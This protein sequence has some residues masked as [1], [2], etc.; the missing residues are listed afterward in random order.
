MEI[1]HKIEKSLEQ[2][3]KALPSLPNDTKKGLASIWPW[4]AL[5]AGVLQ[6]LATWSL[7]TFARDVN[8]WVD[9]A[10][11]WSVAFGGGRVANSGFTVWVW[12][13]IVVLAVDAI[14]L[15]VAFP[16]LQKK[17][18]S[19]WDLLFLAA[20]INVVYGVVSLFIDGRGGAGSLLFSLIGSAIGFYLLF[21][22][23][24]YFGGN[25]LANE[26]SAKPTDSTKTTDEE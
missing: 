23:R 10:N 26:S 16:K 20:L 8:R 7:Y 5:I 17:Q 6:L 9:V 13:A 12:I 3:F 11:E 18:K 4:L 24:E 1:V 15:L 25:K 21:Q 2:P 14:I 19:G 22:V